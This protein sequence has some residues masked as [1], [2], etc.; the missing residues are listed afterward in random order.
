M[1]IIYVNSFL[2]STNFIFRDLWF[3]FSY[4]GIHF[5][6]DESIVTLTSYNLFHI[7]FRRVYS[8]RTG[9]YF[10]IQLNLPKY[11][12]LN[13]TAKFYSKISKKL[14]SEKSIKVNFISS[15]F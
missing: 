9:N 8:T 1:K 15:I 2:I 14:K 10:N 12:T 5:E 6:I 13:S 4:F 3:I 11:S 7:D